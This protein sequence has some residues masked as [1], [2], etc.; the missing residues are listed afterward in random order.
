MNL[1]NDFSKIFKIIIQ[2][3]LSKTAY[4]NVSYSKTKQLEYFKDNFKQIKKN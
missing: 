4:H 1:V 2:A 3:K